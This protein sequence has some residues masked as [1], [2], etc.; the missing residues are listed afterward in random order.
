MGTDLYTV[1]NHSIKTKHRQL[2]NI[3][4]EVCEKLNLIEFPNSNFLRLSRLNSAWSPYS[5]RTVNTKRDWTYRYT[6]RSRSKYYELSI[7]FNGPYG[8]YL[9]LYRHRICFFDPHYRY[10]QWFT[11]K[12][13]ENYHLV[14]NEWRKYFYLVVTA[15]GGNRVVYLSDNG[16]H[17]DKFRDETGSFEETEN[18]LFKEFG[19]PKKRFDEVAKDIDNSYFI[20]YLDDIK[21]DLHCPTDHLVQEKSDKISIDIDVNKYRNLEFVFYQFNYYASNNFLL[22]KV[23]DG[24]YHYRKVL[25]F[26]G[27]I[28]KHFG[29][30]DENETFEYLLDEYAPFHFDELEKE[31]KNEGFAYG[32]GKL[33][34]LYFR[35]RKSYNEWRDAIDM[36]NDLLYWDSNG[37][38]GVEILGERKVEYHY[39]LIDI[40]SFIT[41]L[42]LLREEYQ[43]KSGLEVFEY[44]EKYKKN[45]IFKFDKIKDRYNADVVSTEKSQLIKERIKKLRFMYENEDSID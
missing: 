24:K 32:I 17:L 20:D 43:I 12:P 7:D 36:L 14:I 41:T 2:E 13:W 19:A 1:G 3:A 25:R 26:E 27:L 45:L 31:L 6:E 38:S 28:I 42:K 21:W 23:I 40:E 18:S 5:I 30:Y 22:H 16:S 15:L 39:D 33:V 44:D 11:D 10:W 8:L 37:D 29:V 9:I 35:G 34:A 4:K